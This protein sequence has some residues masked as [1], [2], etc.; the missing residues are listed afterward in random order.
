MD[1]SHNIEQEIRKLIYLVVIMSIV[2]MLIFGLGG[3]F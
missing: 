3:I 2:V 1:Q